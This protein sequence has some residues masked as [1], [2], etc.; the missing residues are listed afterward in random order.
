MKVS[1]D[2]WKYGTVVAHISRKSTLSLHSEEIQE[3]KNAR[4]KSLHLPVVL[5]ALGLLR[6]FPTNFQRPQTCP[7]ARPR[8]GGGRS[9]QKESERCRGQFTWR[10]VRAPRGGRVLRARPTRR[11]LGRNACAPGA[12][13]KARLKVTTAESLWAPRRPARRSSSPAGSKEAEPTLL[14]PPALSARLSSTQHHASSR[15]PF[16][17]RNE[18]VAAQHGR[19]EPNGREAGK[20]GERRTVG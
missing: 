10:Q 14:Y 18:A 6:R 12:Q 9:S 1:L 5:S 13:R 3:V 4:R 16:N 2:W 19:C 20:G 15:A 8:A 7:R 11:A 17:W